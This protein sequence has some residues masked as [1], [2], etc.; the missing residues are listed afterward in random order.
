M[1]KEVVLILCITFL[2]TLVLAVEDTSSS[3]LTKEGID[4]PELQQIKINNFQLG[5]IAKVE[6]LIDNSQ[7]ALLEDVH[8]QVKIFDETGILISTF[9][10]PSTSLEPSSKKIL[11]S[12]WDTIGIKQEGYK[13]KAIIYYNNKTIET[14]FQLSI[15][16]DRVE[17]TGVGYISSPREE[18]KDFKISENLVM[19]LVIVI[20]IIIIINII[21]FLM[22]KDRLGR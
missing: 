22:L 18:S 21:W 17:V 14:D 7:F 11:T 9:D 3:T 12:F 10:S 2:L 20:G 13:A 15:K 4:P 5:K 8:T 16:Q 19:I 6:L 1:K